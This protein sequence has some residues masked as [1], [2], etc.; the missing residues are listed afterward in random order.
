MRISGELYLDG[1]TRDWAVRNT[2]NGLFQI[3]ASASGTIPISIGLS[4]VAFNVPVT[5]SGSLTPTGQILAQSGS[6]SSPGFAFSSDNNLGLY[7]TAEN[8]AAF[9]GSLAINTSF[10]VGTTTFDGRYRVLVT[11]S[12][13][14]S[15]AGSDAAFMRLSGTLTGAAGDTSNLSALKVQPTGIVTPNS[16]ETF[17]LVASVYLD[18]PVIT[19]GATDTITSTATL[20]IAGN[21]SE[22]VSNYA[23]FVD[24]G[25][26]RFDGML[27]IQIAAG[28]PNI[29]FSAAT[30]DTPSSSPETDAEAGWIEILVG[31]DTRYIPFYT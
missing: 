7:R 14:S 20:Y 15:G 4:S 17:T 28:S 5:I 10:N 3:V 8:E 2:P 23:L 25:L 21:A 22:G 29:R 6:S 19:K 9:Q 13:T 27:D 12:L 1:S 30:S 11:G 16:G 26:S 24:G 31:A 18:E